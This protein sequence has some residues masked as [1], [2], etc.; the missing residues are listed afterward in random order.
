MAVVSYG[1][2]L[3]IIGPRCRVIYGGLWKTKTK[4]KPRQK[5]LT[6]SLKGKRKYLGTHCVLGGKHKAVRVI[7]SG[8]TL[9]WR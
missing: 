9:Q 5:N 3:G 4:V 6:C 2:S 8:Q 1:N 7:P